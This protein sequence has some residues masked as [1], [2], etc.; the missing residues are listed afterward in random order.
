M[1]TSRALRGFP[2]ANAFFAASLVFILSF[3][4]GLVRA[5]NS[6]TGTITGRVLNQGTGEYLRNA[7]ITVPGTTLTA[8]A[9]AGG[10]FTLRDVPAGATKVLVSY[11]GLDP[12]EE[13]VLVT[14]GQALALDVTLTSGAYADKGV[15][16]LDAFVV[17]TEREGNAKAIMEQKNSIEAKNVIASDTFGSI[18]EGNVGEFLKYMPGVMIDYTEADARSVSLGGLDTKYTA[19]TIDGNPIASSGLAAAS[20]TTATRG[21]E[22]EQISINSIELVELSRTPQPENPGSALAG[23][24]NLRS[25][26]AFDVAGRR[27]TLNAGLAYNSMSGNPFKKHPGWDDED[28]YRIQPNFGVEYSDVFLKKRL[29]IRAGYNSS[30]TFSEQKAQTTTYSY[31]T[32]LTDN[33]TEIPRLTAFSF[34][35]SPKPTVRYNAN[36]RVDFKVTPDLWFSARGEYNRYH[37]KFFSRDLTFNFTTTANVPGAAVTLPGVE[38]S[39]SSQTATVGNVSVNQGGGGTNKYGATSNFGFDGH[40]KNG[41]FRADV[42]GSFSRSQ[43]WYKNREFGFFWSINPSSLGNLGLRFNRNGSADPAVQITQTSGPDW[44]NL[45][46][47]PNGF[48]ATTNDRQGEDQ[49]YLFKADMQYALS[50]RTRT[51]VVFKFGQQSSLWVNNADRPI[52]GFNATRLGADG[53]AASADEALA[54]WAEPN[55]RMNF[56]YGGNVNGMTNLDR[57]ALYKDYQANPTYWSAPTAGQL[58]QYSLQNARDAKEQVDALY[59]QT[60]LKFG[61][62]TIA[63]GVRFEHTRGSAYGPTDRGDRDTRKALGLPATGTV[64]TGSLAYIGTRYGSGRAAAHPEYNTWLRYLHTSYRFTPSFVAKASYNQSISRPDMN[65]LIGGLVVTNDDPNDPAPNRANAGNENLQPERSQTLNLNFEYYL[66]GIGSFTVSGYRRDFENL[67]RT[68]VYT[69]PVGGSWNG[70]PLPSTISPN[71]PWEINT[72]DNI[73]RA[74]MSSI[75][76]AYNNTLSFLP[77]EFAR[78]RVNANYSHMKY[79]IYENFYRASNVANLSWVIPFRKFRLGWNS[80]WQEGYRVEAPTGTSGWSNHV[81]ERF[82]HTLDFGWEIRRN[83]TFY[84]TARNIFNQDGGEY[85]GRSD[86]R[87]R[88]VQTGAVWTTGVRAS[89]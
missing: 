44:R 49:R 80:N 53:V 55:Y 2:F 38:Y 25:K 37:A 33:D 6:A 56:N 59:E 28:H 23:I 67:L 30:Q 66:R 85:R 26:G 4:T 54:R 83:T 5:Q 71:E 36:L 27:I 50:G 10:V 14:A 87:T 84:V 1:K 45:A 48:T 69:V 43:T 65:R 58:L 78:I 31:N 17:A 11:A 35:D 3:C 20:G 63:P 16:K 18:S 70:A 40:Y 15:V 34:R 76:F 74:H 61:S 8:T 52:A 68:V 62:A 42:G 7:V 29:G 51:P 88:W 82:T 12:K 41:A 39:L 19:V 9:E 89:F 64:D 57:W 21:F 79:D 86:L 22:F 60:I 75:E 47:Y 73:G 24:V 81:R 13:T 46:N 77:G 72:V 32:N